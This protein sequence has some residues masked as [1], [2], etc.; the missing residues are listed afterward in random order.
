MSDGFDLFVLIL[1]LFALGACAGLMA[2]LLGVGGGIVLVPGLFYIFSF[3]QA[4]FGFDAAH[5]MHVAVGTSLAIIVPTGSSSARSHC[6]KGGVDLS[7]VR[8]LALGIVLGV[9]IAMF[10]AQAVSGEILRIIFAFF[11]IIV[12][13]LM[14]FG[15]SRFEVMVSD[16]VFKK[17][18]AIFAGG[19]IG[20][21]SSLIGIGGA[22][23]SVPYMLMKGMPM[24]RAVGTASFLGLVIS[25][26]AAIGFIIIGWA[27]PNLPPMS[28]GYVNILAWLCVVSISVFCAPIGA[29]LAHRI[30]VRRLQLF[31]AVFMIL[32]SMKMWYE[33]ATG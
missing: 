18:Q 15:R 25:I 19:I 28:L 26:P 30:S 21:V 31:F 7:C 23:M 33:I 32:V 22:T 1:M 24:R 6:R 4:D 2:G 20:C 10:F 14:M 29:N 17:P 5:I 11:L 27:V 8:V 9:V 16:V 3:L 12:A 13:I